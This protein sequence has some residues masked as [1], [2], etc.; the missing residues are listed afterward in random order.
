MPPTGLLYDPETKIWLQFDTPLQTFT[1]KSLADVPKLL[2]TIEAEVEQRALHAVGFVSYEASP[3]FEPTAETLPAADF[4]LLWFGLFEAPKEVPPPTTEA[5]PVKIDWRPALT[6]T[7]FGIAVDRIKT[8]I[9]AGETYQVNFTFPLTARYSDAPWPIFCRLM[10]NQ[11]DSYGAWLDTGRYAIASASPE[12]FFERDNDRLMSKPMKGTG[13][14][15]LTLEED[16]IKADTLQASAKERAEN[17]MVLDMIRNDLARLPG[18]PVQV[19]EL[20]RVEKHPTVWQMT[21]TAATITDASL[22]EIFAKLFPCASITGAPKL[23]TMHHIAALETTPRGIYTGAIGH[24]APNRQARFS[25]A[26]RT[27]F[28]DRETQTATYGIGAGITWGSD[29]AAEYREC[30]AKAQILHQTRPSFALLESLLWEPETGYFLFDEHLQRLKNAAEYFDYPFDQDAI[31]NKLR[32][33]TDKLTQ[34]AHKVRLLLDQSGKLTSEAMVIA[35]PETG[36]VL[37]VRLAG[38]AVSTNDPFLY[39]KTTARAVYES[40]RQSVDNCDEVLLFNEQGEVTEA[41]NANL[42]AKLDGKLVTPPIKC[43]LLGGT[44]RS[45]LL[46]TGEIHEQVI[47]VNDLPRCTELYLIN[48][49]RRWRRAELSTNR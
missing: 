34:S 15:G 49:V 1:T 26:I 10:Q 22:V 29:P 38:S 27:A 21:S 4:P 39:H 33:M 24:I 14:R 43:G 37:Q 7:D 47:K 16:R 2:A 48:S 25:V 9:A 31:T 28:I 45:H 44:L 3:A 11:P 42:V 40:A 41:C 30:L 20:C 35:P 8:A 36:V 46:A 12:L 19:E 13:I 17:I 23:R 18:G 5:A 6:E 32:Q